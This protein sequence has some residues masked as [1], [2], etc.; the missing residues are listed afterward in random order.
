MV[1]QVKTDEA[2]YL[3]KDGRNFFVSLEALCAFKVF[4]DSFYVLSRYDRVFVRVK[5]C[6]KI[7]GSSVRYL[8]C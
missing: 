6:S 4:D 7:L 3:Q 5:F 2:V 1:L 8:H